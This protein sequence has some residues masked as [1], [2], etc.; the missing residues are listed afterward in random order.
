MSP[1]PGMSLLLGGF[2]VGK[3]TF[4]V[5]V[6]GRMQLSGSDLRSTGA[7]AS[8]VPIRDGL[9]SL[10]KGVPVS[11]TPSGVE[12]VQELN[13]Q[14]RDGLQ[15][16]ISVPDYAGESLDAIV[17]NRQVPEHWR[18]RCLQSNRW[19]L[20]VRL[21]RMGEVPDFIAADAQSRGLADQTDVPLPL[22]MRLVELLQMLWLERKRQE[23]LAD[24]P[25]LVVVLSCWDEITSLVPAIEPGRLL[26]DRMPLLSSFAETNWNRDKMTVV[27]L[28]AQGR[29]LAEAEPDGDFVDLGPEE[30]GYL[31]R[32]DGTSTTDLTELLLL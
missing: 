32:A 30:M 22:D 25:S 10:A 28:S 21:E 8:L 7:P 13:V 16:D 27:G 4:L 18:E 15:L 26:Q 23:A 29:F 24:R 19:I 3:T 20:F 17:E 5:Q 31:V 12:V 11:H 9:A 6:F 14:T 1:S 2:G